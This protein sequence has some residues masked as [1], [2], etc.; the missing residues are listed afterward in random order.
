M[1]YKAFAK[2]FM[3][4]ISFYV[5]YSVVIYFFCLARLVGYMIRHQV[6]HRKVTGVQ[7]DHGHLVCYHGNTFSLLSGW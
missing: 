3:V 2:L 5:G 6:C 7:E 1:H 4:V